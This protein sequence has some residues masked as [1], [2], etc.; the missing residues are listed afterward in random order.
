MRRKITKAAVD[1]LE[2]GDNLADTEIKGF[3]ARRL[4]SGAV[5]YG[6]RYRVAGKQR[7]FALGLHGRITPDKARQLAKKRM[8]EVADARDPAGE[9][10]AERVK[11]EEDSAH[12]VE[13]LLDNFVKRYIRA[14]NLR[15]GDRIERLFARCVRPLIGDKSIYELRRRDI[16]QMLDAVED[17]RGAGVA[18]K[19]L[20]H[21]GTAFTWQ[22]SRDDDFASPI[23]KGM[24]RTKPVERERILSDEEI[25]DVWRALHVA[26]VP[27]LYPTF[28]RALLHTAQRREELGRMRWEEIEGD[29]WI[30]PAQKYKTKISHMVPLTGAVQALSGAPQ[31][32]GFA[33]TTTAGRRRSAPIHGRKLH[34]MRQSQSCARGT[35]VSRWSRGC[36]T[37]SDAR[38]AH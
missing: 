1:A 30:I 25:R 15:S 4:P 28:V 22:A 13:A 21:L 31:T 6:I 36:C 35:G 23:T 10:E 19:V 27:T 14:K 2:P 17:E 3:V 18:D 16:V 8:G 24:R 20:A 26:P 9:R 29:V 37:I 32:R 5:T 7:W 33:F 34:S 12:T 38:R 11:A